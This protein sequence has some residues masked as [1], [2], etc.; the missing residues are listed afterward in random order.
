MEE[1]YFSSSS[2]ITI[3]ND[4]YNLENLKKLYIKGNLSSLPNEIYKL[5]K[6]KYLYINGMIIKS[7]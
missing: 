7:L 1:L 5:K 3:E 4:F 6:L 2:L